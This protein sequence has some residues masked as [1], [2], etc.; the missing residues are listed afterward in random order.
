M[1]EK[2]RDIQFEQAQNTLN[3]YL[4]NCKA[5]YNRQVF[6]GVVLWLVRYQH[7]LHRFNVP[8]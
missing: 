4:F 5:P 1:P 8:L 2:Q 7:W 3:N 6:C